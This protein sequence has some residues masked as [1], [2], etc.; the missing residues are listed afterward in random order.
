MTIK[1]ET[2]KS[3]FTRSVCDHDTIFDITVV[4]RTAKTI[5]TECGKTL[6]V[7]VYNGVEQ[8]KPFGTYSMCAIIGADKPL[9]EKDPVEH[10]QER[11][12][13]SVV[14]LTR[15]ELIDGSDNVVRLFG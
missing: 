7:S 12:G 4:R 1:F 13:G 8:V 9:V 11:F 6:R 10:A 5:W 2:G 14:V 3:Y 15:D